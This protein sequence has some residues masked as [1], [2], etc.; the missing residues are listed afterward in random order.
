MFAMYWGTGNAL[1]AFFFAFTIP[2]LFRRILGEGALSEAFIPVFT[3]KLTKGSRKD[4][5]RLASTVLSLAVAALTVLVAFGVGFC[6]WLQ[7]L[8]TSEFAQ[9]VLKV[10][11][12][13]LPYTIF[14]CVV[15]LFSGILNSLNHFSI[16]ALTP[17]IL[18]LVLI[19]TVVW[20][21][22]RLGPDDTRRLL[23]LA[24]AVLFAG[25]LQLIALLPSLANF[26]FQFR[27]NLNWRSAEI[28][29]VFRLLIPGVFGAS[30]GQINVL[31]DRLFAG[32]LGGYAVTSLYYS[33]RII[34]LPIGVFGVALATACLPELSRAHATD[35]TEEM[36]ESLF[37]A[38]RQII[39]LTIPCA[40]F[41]ILLAPTI[42]DLLYR[43]GS[44]DDAS[45]AYTIAAILFYAPGIPAFAAVKIIRTGF[46]S[47][48]NTKTP[49][50]VGCLCLIIN[51]VL[52]A[53]LIGPLQHR[54]LA[55]A[56]TI[57][58]YVN[59]IALT[60]IFAQSLKPFRLPIR[61]FCL[62]ILRILTAISGSGF[63]IWILD[64]H[65]IYCSGY[66][67]VDKLLAFFVPCSAGLLAYIVFTLSIGSPEPREF[68]AS[69]RKKFDR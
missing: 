27:F 8:M 32:F 57:S 29:E 52:N 23:G 38:L 13:L 21:C 43:R 45:A 48:K 37:F 1:G 2:N 56:T 63:I 19:A 22:P 3:E 28:K 33:E 53:V 15:G 66:G 62:S 35:R 18:N 55:L 39:Y 51:V 58:S 40:V 24:I 42:V 50:Q 14:I 41:I 6:L 46:Y 25:V 60:V 26:E 4:A 31:C 7:P 11:P 68:A 30:I 64:K 9:L 44:F 16:P 49:V 67:I 47:R 61:E 54:G 59:L 20:V 65:V 69:L 10:L 5:F 17:I 36:I 34:Y 12:I